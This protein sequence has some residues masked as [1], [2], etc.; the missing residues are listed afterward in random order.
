M[1]G[2]AQEQGL[3]RTPLHARHEAL[4]A[5][6]VGFAGWEMPVQYRG[7]QAE[8]SAVRSGAGLFDVSH[9]GEIDVT[10]AGASR[11][12]QRLTTNDIERLSRRRRSTR[13]C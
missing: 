2:E 10:G 9:M 6:M 11:F 1:A 5:R 4:G 8:H 3:A 13:C 12:C 7:I